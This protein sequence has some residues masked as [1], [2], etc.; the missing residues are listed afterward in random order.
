MMCLEGGHS[1]LGSED[2]HLVAAALGAAFDDLVGIGDGLRESVLLDCICACGER[3]R[4]T[5]EVRGMRCAKT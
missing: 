2:E 3:R 5:A 1:Y 4:D